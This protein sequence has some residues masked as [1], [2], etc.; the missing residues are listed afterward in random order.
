VAQ[1]NKIKYENEEDSVVSEHGENHSHGELT[2]M[3]RERENELEQNA[4]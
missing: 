3:E 1:Q 4:N 2:E